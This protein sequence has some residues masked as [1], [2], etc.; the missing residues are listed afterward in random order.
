ME[1]KESPKGREKGPEESN[2]I[3]EGVVLEWTSP[4][5]LPILRVVASITCF[6]F[7]LTQSPVIPSAF[8]RPPQYLT[9]EN[10]AN[11]GNYISNSANLATVQRGIDNLREDQRHRLN[12]ENAQ[13]MGQLTARAGMT[14]NLQLLTG[15]VGQGGEAIERASSFGSSRIQE[16]AGVTTPFNYLVQRQDDPTGKYPYVKIFFKNSRADSVWHEVVKGPGG[17]SYRNTRDMKYDENGLLASYASTEVREIPGMS[18]PLVLRETVWKG[19]WKEGS[20]FYATQE[21]KAVKQLLQEELSVTQYN[22]LTQG[23]VDSM[24]AKIA[25]IDGKAE[26]A[27]ALAY[28]AAMRKEMDEG[29][30]AAGVTRQY[31]T[32][33]QRSFTQHDRS[34]PLAWRQKVTDPTGVTESDVTVAYEGDSDKKLATYNEVGVRR[35]V[36][37]TEEEFKTIQELAGTLAGSASPQERTVGRKVTG[38]ITSGLLSPGRTLETQFT[39]QRKYLQYHSQFEEPTHYTERRTSSLNPSVVTEEEVKLEYDSQQRV[40]RREQLVTENGALQAEDVAA[41]RRRAE[42]IQARKLDGSNHL[43]DG[44]EITQGMEEWTEETLQEL[45]GGQLSVGKP[46]SRRSRVVQQGFVYNDALQEVERQQTTQIQVGD[47]PEAE[48]T[49]V[50]ER[51]LTYDNDPLGRTIRQ[52][53]F[54]EEETPLTDSSRR[55]FR[56]QA[57]AV[58]EDPASTEAAREAARAALVQLEKGD[59]GFFFRRRS[60][61][62]QHVQLRNGAGLPLHTVEY[63]TSNADRFLTVT[64]IPLVVYD[65]KGQELASLTRIQRTGASTHSIYRLKDGGRLTPVLLKELL[66]KR[67]TPTQVATL[68][69]LEAAGDILLDPAATDSFSLNQTVAR[70]GMAYDSAGRLIDAVEESRDPTTLLDTTT[71]TF[72]VTYDSKNR[73]DRFLSISRRQS[74]A[75]R[76]AL[77]SQGK[78]LDAYDLHD[79]VEETGL[80]PSELLEGGILEER[81]VL[82]PVDQT[83]VAYR[84]ESRYQDNSN[85]LSRTSEVINTRGLGEDGVTE[86]LKTDLIFYDEAG[87]PLSQLVTSRRQGVGMMTVQMIGGEELRYENLKALQEAHPD[88]GL[89]DLFHEGLIRTAT[90]PTVVDLRTDTFRDRIRY[91]RDTGFVEHQEE[92]VTGDTNPGQSKTTFHTA[93]YTSAGQLKSAVTE[94]EYNLFDLEGNRST[95]LTD[96]SRDDQGRLIW[97]RGAGTQ[98]SF[99]IFGNRSRSVMDQI[100]VGAAGQP[101]IALNDAKGLATEVAGDRYRIR[102]LTASDVDLNGNPIRTDGSSSKEGSDIFGNR[103]R[104]FFRNI[105]VQINR[106][107]RVKLSYSVDGPAWVDPSIAGTGFTPLTAGEQQQAGGSSPV[108]VLANPGDYDRVSLAKYGSVEV[109]QF[110]KKSDQSLAGVLIEIPGAAPITLSE[111]VTQPVVTDGQ[112]VIEAGTG[113]GRS[114]YT[115]RQEGAAAVRITRSS[116]DSSASRWVPVQEAL[117]GPGFIRQDDY[118]RSDQTAGST[119]AQRTIL[120]SNQETGAADQIIRITYDAYDPAV[121]NPTGQVRRVYLEQYNSFGAAVKVME[122]ERGSDGELRWAKR[123]DYDPSGN[124]RVMQLERR[125]HQDGSSYLT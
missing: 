4:R 125:S 97:A 16:W 55:N 15:E 19:K 73:Q 57:E 31:T 76:T 68:A 56:R 110:I 20:K 45:N 102:Q 28:A 112:T 113:A 13:L 119:V 111:G 91:N 33:T 116:F 115:L 124:R 77:F 26:S 1:K 78:E 94:T 104:R 87:R 23:D 21:T 49:T 61:R 52:L 80:S 71:R 66:E 100:F 38:M 7:I 107:A 118:R 9:P 30:I 11:I 41:L 62:Y 84:K 39:V 69:D 47:T 59:T 50:K 37:L 10:V 36:P 103:S 75:Y 114:Q 54:T 25:E 117:F 22:T 108:P 89:K 60:V 18:Q 74:E 63:S 83:V 67:S 121:S 12:L 99:D 65:R 14:Q 105:Y 46:F 2:L 43:E 82:L 81:S 5:R 3:P 90:R 86:S 53:I 92:T 32:V 106:E 34:R 95:V 88:K 44:T 122:L 98:E 27:A 79:L 35:S 40:T 17:V 64:E 101:R 6:T 93:T 109:A 58:L 85:L 29:R 48:A 8:A 51:I 96:Y 42:E 123:Q 24:K 70:Y 72:G 120:F